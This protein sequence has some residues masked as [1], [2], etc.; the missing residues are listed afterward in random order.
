MLATAPA[1][2][3]LNRHSRVCRHVAARNRIEDRVGGEL[4]R[5]RRSRK[6]LSA[7]TRC[8]T[9]V[10]PAVSIAGVDWLAVSRA[11]GGIPMHRDMA[12]PVRA[13]TE[14]SSSSRYGNRTLVPE[15]TRAI[16]EKLRAHV[17]ANA[18][19]NESQDIASAES[20]PSSGAITL[21]IATFIGLWIPW[22]G[23]AYGYVEVGGFHSGIF[24]AGTTGFLLFTAA[25]WVVTPLFT[26]IY[27]FYAMRSALRKYIRPSNVRR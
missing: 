12:P 2:A 5:R 20:G 24:T 14:T 9:I 26:L 13:R 21:A 4:C 15:N 19:M 10:K 18:T 6:T 25:T 11:A 1:V 16:G 27:V 22:I 3:R 17:R 23:F 8:L 7:T